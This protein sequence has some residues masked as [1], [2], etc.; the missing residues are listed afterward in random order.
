MSDERKIDRFDKYMKAK[1][2]NDNRVTIDLGLSVGTIGKSR[3]EGRDISDKAVEA[4]LNFYD[5]V[6]RVWLLT[7]EGE[8]L[9]KELSLS[10]KGDNPVIRYW[11]E[12]EATGGGML[13]FNDAANSNYVEMKLPNFQDCTDALPLVGDS[14]YPRLKA[15]Q[16]LILKEW[17]ES[18]IEY[19]QVYLVVTRNGHRMVKYLRAGGTPDKVL[20]V[21]ENTEMYTPFEIER[22]DIHK[23]YLVKGAIEQSS[24]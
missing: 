24:Y 4:I 11:P 23:L 15:G 10:Q 18:F 5:D 8:M 7:G 22:R 2:L 6:N 9:K 21:S 13:S 12:I 16:V 19:G 17:T 3:K 14:M 1:G 20:C